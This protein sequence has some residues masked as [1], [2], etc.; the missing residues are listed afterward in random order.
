MPGEPTLVEDLEA[1]AYVLRLRAAN[2]IQPPLDSTL[3]ARLRAAAERLRSEMANWGVNCW[4][5]EDGATYRALER[6]NGGP[7]PR[8]GE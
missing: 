5:D 3:G 6:I 4:T 8:D 1:A 7:L 2:D